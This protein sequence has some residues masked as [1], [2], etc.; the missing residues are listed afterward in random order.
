MASLGLRYFV[1]LKKLCIPQALERLAWEAP[2]LHRPAHKHQK[3]QMEPTCPQLILPMSLS[4]VKQKAVC[5]KWD[6]L[7]RGIWNPTVPSEPVYFSAMGRMASLCRN[8][9]GT[10]FAP[11][12]ILPK[13]RVLKTSR[14]TF[15]FVTTTASPWSSAAQESYFPFGRDLRY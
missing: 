7:S 2:G 12:Q 1:R 13:K 8:D 6:S 3:N 9:K 11:R 4:P 14:R 15:Q 10:V 5:P